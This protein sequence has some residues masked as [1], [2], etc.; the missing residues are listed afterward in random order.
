[1]TDKYK[2]EE[3]STEL[4]SYAKRLDSLKKGDKGKP[5]YHLPFIT[6]LLQL[7]LHLA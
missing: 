7:L 6:Q 1:M 2:L 4:D 5:S 3:E